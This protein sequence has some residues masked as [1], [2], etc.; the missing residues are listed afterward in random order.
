MGR[1]EDLYAGIEL[2]GEHAIE[3]FI[4]TRKSEELFLDFKRS[5]DDGKGTRLSD[6]DRNNLV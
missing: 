6:G 5:S 1:A 4:A 3:E 2:Q